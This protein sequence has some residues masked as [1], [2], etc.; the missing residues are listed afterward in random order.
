MG[1][2]KPDPSHLEA[3]EGITFM[4]DRDGVIMAIGA[5]NWDA[6]C[7]D[8]GA[9]DLA[10]SDVIGR[11]LFDYVSGKPVRAQIRE[12]LDKL[13]KSPENSWVMPF[14]CDAPGRQ[15]HM[16][17]SVTPVFRDRKCTGFFFQS[18][19]LASHDRPP[20]DLFDFKEMARKAANSSDLP[21][22]KMC[23]WCQKVLFTPVTN[24]DW[25]EAE[26]YYAAGG[27]SNVRI[28]HGICAPCAEKASSL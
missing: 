19:E 6:F 12:A 27:S 11:N 15:R 3:L 7:V 26:E 14:R 1:H 18:I 8:N 21:L 25:V 5:R 23:S 24:D 28:S 20:I 4:T 22:I 16:R 2:V 10:A 9:P 17:Q 13:A